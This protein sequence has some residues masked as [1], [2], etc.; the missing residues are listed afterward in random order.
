[1][2]QL[3]SKQANHF[4]PLELKLQSKISF[5]QLTFSQFLSLGWNMGTRKPSLFLTTSLNLLFLLNVD[6]TFKPVV[7]MYFSALLLLNFKAKTHSTR[8]HSHNS[9]AWRWKYG[10]RRTFPLFLMTS[11]NF[12][13]WL[14]MGQN[15][16]SM[17]F[18]Y[19]F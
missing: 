5:S 14:T 15:I 16:R 8:M 10:Y 3:D 9:E 18:F 17:Y 7:F 1:M 4:L 12:L 11:L 13:F 6:Q 19:I 2:P